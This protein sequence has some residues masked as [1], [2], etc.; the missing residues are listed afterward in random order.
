MDGV[1]GVGI[2]GAGRW[3][4]AHAQIYNCNVQTRIRG[5]FD[6]NNSRAEYLA[7]TYGGV[8]YSSL[9]DLLADSSIK[10]VSVVTPEA[11]H[12]EPVLKAVDAGKAFYV[13]K[14]LATTMEDVKTLQDAAAGRIAMGGH[15]LRFES[16][17][18]A[19]KESI[20]EY[21]R[22]E[23]MYFR[24]I[25]PHQEKE[26]YSR[27]HTALIM[28]SHDINIANWY[29][30]T[31]F[32]R[33][34]AMEGRYRGEPMADAM[35][36]LVEY[37]NGVTATLESGWLIPNDAGYDADDRVSVACA[38][39]SFEL[40]IPGNDFYQYS[41]GGSQ[42]PNLYYDL[43]V[44]DQRYGPLRAALDYAANCVLHGEIAAQNTIED[45]AETVL[46]ALT[47]IRSA[48]EN[49]FVDRAEMI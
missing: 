43:E 22:V 3:G 8:A 13:E 36:I 15:L 49:R 48:K 4:E 5:V 30:G 31:P 12:V 23:H 42:I 16:R 29:A 1:I 44:G 17:Y 27:T 6:P 26:T 25:R 41:V 2:I 33:I 47:A 14:P 32:K 11:L 7:E 10:L 24:R 34:V 19:I 45:A 46:F 35:S 18:R 9:E 38:Q 20:H 37:E 21:G 28:Q 39:G 40:R